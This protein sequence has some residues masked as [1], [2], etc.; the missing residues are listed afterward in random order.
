M[1]VSIV[2]MATQERDDDE[3]EEL[4]KGEINQVLPFYIPRPSFVEIES[5]IPIGSDKN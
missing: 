2:V 4:G 3:K 1:P 5:S